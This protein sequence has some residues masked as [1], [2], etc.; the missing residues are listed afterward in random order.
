[1]LKVPDELLA[2]RMFIDKGK[3]IEIAL[4]IANHP[5]II[6][7]LK[8]A[9]VAVIILNAL[10]LQLRAFLSGQLVFIARSFCQSGAVL[11]IAQQRFATVRTHT[12]G[13]AGQLHL[14]HSQIDAHL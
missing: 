1:M 6:V 7:Q 11:M 10:L 9:N 14:Q 12:I 13:A 3:K 5:G 2:L 4:G 8:E